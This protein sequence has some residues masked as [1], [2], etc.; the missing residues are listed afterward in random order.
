MPT[1][2]TRTSISGPTP[3]TTEYPESVLTESLYLLS[4]SVQRRLNRPDN[5]TDYFVKN[6]RIDRNGGYVIFAA[7]SNFYYV[8]QSICPTQALRRRGVYD[9]NGARFYPIGIIRLVQPAKLRAEIY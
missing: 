7:E 2:I 4:D 3:E 6:H 5:V 9:R 8:R 1:G